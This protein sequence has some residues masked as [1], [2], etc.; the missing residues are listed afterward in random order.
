MYFY[1]NV[2]SWVRLTCRPEVT[3]R[4]FET[5]YLILHN[6]I[7]KG[8]LVCVLISYKIKSKSDNDVHFD[9]E[10]CLSLN[11]SD[12]HMFDTNTKVYI[13]YFVIGLVRL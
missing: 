13:S 10:K 3:N 4:I 5:T 7:Q 1:G 12:L 6:N 11:P 2:E 8:A 9:K